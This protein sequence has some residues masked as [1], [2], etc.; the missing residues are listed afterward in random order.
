[1]LGKEACSIQLGTTM[2]RL[3][4]ML[5]GITPK[6]LKMLLWYGGIT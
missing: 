2:L 6:V 3:V 5:C 4:I 1:M